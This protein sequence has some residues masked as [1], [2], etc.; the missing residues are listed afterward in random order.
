MDS[1]PSLKHC[2]RSAGLARIPSC[3]PPWWLQ[4]MPAALAPLSTPQT[5]ESKSKACRSFGWV[6]CSECT[7]WC[8][9]SEWRRTVACQGQRG[10][11]SELVVF[12]GGGSWN[13]TSLFCW[14]SY[15]HWRCT[16]PGSQ[17]F[18]AH[19][20]RLLAT[21]AETFCPL[22]AQEQFE[23]LPWNCMWGFVPQKP[24]SVLAGSV[25]LNAAPVILP[26]L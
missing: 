19:K 16:Q 8:V 3:K 2:G 5:Q 7:W 4:K 13:R 18:P 14:W 17:S 15:C 23:L 6:N 9:R 25:E 12:Q 21:W 24:G 20:S 1:K 10:V 11:D 26:P 22:N